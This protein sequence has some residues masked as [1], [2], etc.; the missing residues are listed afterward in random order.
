MSEQ[1][2]AHR[3][4]GVA[5]LSM[6]RIALGTH[7]LYLSNKLSIWDY[8]AAQIILEEVGGVVEFPYTT[9]SRMNTKSVVLSAAASKKLLAQVYSLMFK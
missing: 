4:F 2:F 3:C 9:E 6:C 5:S 8:A 7:E 1:V